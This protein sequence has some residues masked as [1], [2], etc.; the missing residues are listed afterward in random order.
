MALLSSTI[1]INNYLPTEPTYWCIG[2]AHW[3][4][5]EKVID[6]IMFGFFNEAH[7]LTGLGNKIN[8]K[9]YRF[10]TGDVS[11]IDEPTMYY[12]I[13]TAPEFSNALDHP[14]II[15]GGTTENSPV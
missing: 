11:Y 10:N 4:K 8:S 13:K 2:E 6:I 1:E 14:E 5:A 7:R 12:L 3:Y 15:D 9:G